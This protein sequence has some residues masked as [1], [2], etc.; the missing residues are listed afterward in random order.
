MFI[1]RYDKKGMSPVQTE[2]NI[3]EKD[4]EIGLDKFLCKYTSEDNDSFETILERY[5]LHHRFI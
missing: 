4:K 5:K 2:E 1:F 3:K